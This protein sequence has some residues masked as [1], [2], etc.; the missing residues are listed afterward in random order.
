MLS[1]IKA[2]EQLAI[3]I[4]K[5]FLLWVSQKSL[6]RELTDSATVSSPISGLMQIAGQ[7]LMGLTLVDIHHLRTY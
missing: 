3:L 4:K 1:N 7:Y 5:L 6:A 2:T